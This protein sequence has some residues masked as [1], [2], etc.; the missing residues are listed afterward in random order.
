MVIFILTVVYIEKSKKNKKK[1]EK[2]MPCDSTGENS[3]AL[4]KNG[5]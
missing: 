1:K 3:A 4:G 2:S 5:Q